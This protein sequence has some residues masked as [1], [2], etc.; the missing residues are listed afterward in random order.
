M[1]AKANYGKG[2]RFRIAKEGAAI[3]GMEHVGGWTRRPWRIELAKGAFAEFSPGACGLASRNRASLSRRGKPF[4][5]LS[6]HPY[7]SASPLWGAPEG[8]A[9]AKLPCTPYWPPPLTSGAFGRAG[10]S[11]SAD[12]LPGGPA[13]VDFFMSERGR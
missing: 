13:L 8:P 10:P 7:F 3:V 5:N 4:G 2:E 12:L 9:V 1:S 6:G 11:P